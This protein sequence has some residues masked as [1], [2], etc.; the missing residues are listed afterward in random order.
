MSDEAKVGLLVVVALAVFVTTFLYVANVQLTGATTEY[1]AYFAYV[2]GLDGGSVVRYGGRKAGT[3]RSVQSWPDDMTKTEVVFQMRAEIP[4][5]EQSVATIASLNALGQNYLEIT[6]GSIDAPRVKPGGVVRST[7]ALTFSDLTRKVS[8]VADGAVELMARI[9]EKMT[10]VADDMHSVLVNLRELSG[11]ENQRQIARMLRNSNALLETQTPKVDQVTSQLI[12]TLEE[13]ERLA[14]D[15]RHV[16]RGADETLGGINRTIEETRVPLAD[17]LT[18][19]E[20]TL[21]DARVVLADAR[22]L[23]L[24]NE[25]NVTEIVDNFR[26]ASEEI[27][28]L[29]ADLRQRPWTLLRVRPKP[30]RQVPPIAGAGAPGP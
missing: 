27:G 26:R 13:V 17:S 9:D 28:A 21:A 1:R 25:R 11:A 8:E 14:A 4:V 20:G 7:E 18:Q 6:P 3:V 15:F 16:A 23:L 12:E 5:N 29:S 19:L 30:D 22:A 2:G 24:L 10:V